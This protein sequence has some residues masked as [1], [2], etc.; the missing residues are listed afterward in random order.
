MI[1]WDFFTD[2]IQNC[3]PLKK[4]FKALYILF[5]IK[6]KA[7]A[8]T[9]MV[10]SFN[11]KTKNMGNGDMLTGFEPSTNLSLNSILDF[12]MFSDDEERIGVQ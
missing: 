10:I 5:G 3:L 7:S 8:L 4:P 9:K 1:C 2:A 11:L 12:D 6:K